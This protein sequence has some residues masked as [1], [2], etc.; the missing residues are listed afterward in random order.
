MG[1]CVETVVRELST[2][3]DIISCYK[4]QKKKRFI[5]YFNTLQKCYVK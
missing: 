1:Q 4:L 5:E 3:R 2:A